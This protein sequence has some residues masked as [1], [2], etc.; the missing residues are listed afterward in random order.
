MAYLHIFL[1][2]MSW[3]SGRDFKRIFVAQKKLVKLIF[4]MKYNESCRQVFVNNKILTATSIYIFKC[5]T[6]LSK[7]IFIYSLAISVYMTTAQVSELLRIPKYN[8]TTLLS[9]YDCMKFYNNCL[10]I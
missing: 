4:S 9:S 7:V 6:H 5:V 1:N 2:I 8:S 10:L 3:D